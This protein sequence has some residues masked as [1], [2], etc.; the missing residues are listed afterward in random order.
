VKEEYNFY[1]NRC[2]ELAGKALGRTAPNPLVGCVIVHKGKIIGE[3]YHKEFGGPHAEVNAIDSVKDKKKLKTSVLF[4]N[5][6]PCSHYGKTPPCTD[7]IIKMG[8]PEVVIGN[9]D[10]FEKVAGSGIRKLKEAGI[11]VVSGIL[12][13]ECKE[14]NKR[15]FTFQLKKRPYIILKWA[16]TRDGFISPEK[17]PAGRPSWITDEKLK[18]LV[19]KMRSEEQAILVGTNT[20][21]LDNPQLNTR[22]WKGKDPIR[23]VL[24]RNLRL[25]RTLHLFDKSIPTI[26]FTSKNMAKQNAV[27]LEYVKIDFSTNIV[28]QICGILFRKNIQSLFIEGGTMLLQTF[29][30]SGIWDEA[31]LFTGDKEFRKGVKAPVIKGRTINELLFDK[32]SLT[33]LK[34]L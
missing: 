2:I 34:N 12:D 27:N 5:L 22:E 17:K 23:I 26:V 24:D 3:G 9:I 6:E 13:K 16:Q 32:D 21:L 30:D 20:A 25:P 4:V 31:Y 1:I 33:I 10:P 8:I 11:K 19:H 14:L 18:T 15:F 29:I 28:G 7:L